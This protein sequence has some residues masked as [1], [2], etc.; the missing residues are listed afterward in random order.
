[1]NKQVIAIPY[2]YIVITTLVYVILCPI[3]FEMDNALGE[4]DNFILYKDKTITYS[5]QQVIETEC[6]S[7]SF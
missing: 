5:Q 1:M 7:P 2:P 4:G 3:F 6:K